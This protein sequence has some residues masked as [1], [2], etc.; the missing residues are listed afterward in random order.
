MNIIIPVT[1]TQ[2][3]IVSSTF[4][5]TPCSITYT[6]SSSSVSGI[7]R[8][9]WEQW[10]TPLHALLHAWHKIFK[11]LQLKAD[12]VKPLSTANTGVVDNVR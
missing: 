4:S 11:T 6:I 2:Q 7:C 3:H 10:S 12:T 9:E 8:Y 5:S 1:S